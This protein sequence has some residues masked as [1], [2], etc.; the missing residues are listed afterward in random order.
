MANI[1]ANFGIHNANYG[2]Y[3]LPILV[4]IFANFGEHFCPFQ[5]TYLAM[6]KLTLN[7]V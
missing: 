4:N 1:Y 7:Y 3:F 5:V 6:Q 2:K